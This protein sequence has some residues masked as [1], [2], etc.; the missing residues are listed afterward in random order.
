MDFFTSGVMIRLGGA[1]AE[2]NLVVRAMFENPTVT[3]IGA[4]IEQQYVW[5]GLVIFGLLCLQ[6]LKREQR[7]HNRRLKE[8]A[9]AL[10]TVGVVLVWPFAVLRLYSGVVGNLLQI[11]A[12]YGMGAQVMVLVF[13]A[14]VT[15]VAAADF[16]VI[17]LSARRKQ[18]VKG[19][20]SRENE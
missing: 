10:C 17:W 2:G 8:L 15:L 9:Q 19:T 4:A 6:L 13:G 12:I 18:E 14:A 3:T 7:I 1:E 11:V 5:L 16:L 20:R